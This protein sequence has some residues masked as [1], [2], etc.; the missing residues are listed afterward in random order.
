MSKFAFV[1]IALLCAM[2]LPPD[3]QAQEYHGGPLPGSYV[4]YPGG[5]PLSLNPNCVVTKIYSVA[6]QKCFTNQHCKLPN[7]CA[8]GSFGREIYT[9]WR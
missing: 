7:N 1:A 9:P 5:G 8:P 4:Q 6:D 2:G 3:S